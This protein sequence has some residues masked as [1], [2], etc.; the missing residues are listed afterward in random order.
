M[1]IYAIVAYADTDADT[2]ADLN[3]L[4]IADTDT[5]QISRG[6]ACPPIR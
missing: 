5:G 6:H 4:K 3:F 1:V 2:D